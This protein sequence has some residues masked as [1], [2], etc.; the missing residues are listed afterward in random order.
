LLAASCF[1]NEK[2]E[3]DCN[4]A[5]FIVLLSLSML[6]K[7]VA[8]FF[9][10]C[11]LVRRDL[12]ILKK[13]VYTCVPLLIFLMSFIPFWGDGVVQNVFLYRSFKNFPLLFPILNLLSVPASLYFSFFV[14][15]I[16]VSGFLFRDFPTRDFSLLYT[17][18]MVALSSAVANQYFAIP[19]AALFVFKGGIKYLYITLV[20]IYLLLHGDG[21][22]FIWGIY[23]L[24]YPSFP[25][26]AERVFRLFIKI[27]FPLG[28]TIACWLLLFALGQ[29]VKFRNKTVALPE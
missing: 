22:R 3:F 5:I 23:D 19:L 16:C 25:V 4:D 26:F 28:Q 8:A 14:I 11:L 20:G 17:I 18:C 21:L 9:F 15:L 6:V 29:Y 10:F 27:L 13:G 1:Y 7:H 24:M 2:K 12:P